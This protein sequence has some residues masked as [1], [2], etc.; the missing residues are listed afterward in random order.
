MQDRLASLRVH[1]N[2][3]ATSSTTPAATPPSAAQVGM[4]TAFFSDIAKVK[5]PNWA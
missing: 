3:R 2:L 4:A 1:G 5:L